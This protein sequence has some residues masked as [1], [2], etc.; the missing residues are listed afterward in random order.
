VVIIQ[1]AVLDFFLNVQKE[2]A[3]RMV[4]IMGMIVTGLT[5]CA[6]SRHE[7]SAADVQRAESMRPH[8][9]QLAER[10]ERSCMVCHTART[11]GAP[12]TG[13]GPHW[14]QR[15]DRGMEQLVRHAD[16][17]F[18]AM[19]AKGLCND[20]T[21]QDLRALIAFMSGKAPA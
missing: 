17:G 6:A 15:L 16:E 18:N 2:E 19:P 21:P 7:P 14:D 10:Y 11:S 12:L 5:A 20:C 3:M 9:R 13:F 4:L 8:D 1:N